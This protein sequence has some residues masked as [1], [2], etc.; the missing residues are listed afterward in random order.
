MVS[1]D[2]ARTLP[3]RR[4]ENNMLPSSIESL[5][6]SAMSLMKIFVGT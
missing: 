5:A 6:P 3:R 1:G 2:N 4:H